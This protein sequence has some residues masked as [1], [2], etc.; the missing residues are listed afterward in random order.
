MLPPLLALHLVKRR[1][2]WQGIRDELY[3]VRNLA[4]QSLTDTI[5]MVEIDS[6][7]DLMVPIVYCTWA[8]LCHPRQISLCNPLLS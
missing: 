8:N 5:K 4:L 1:C 6:L 2:L 3:Q 7:R